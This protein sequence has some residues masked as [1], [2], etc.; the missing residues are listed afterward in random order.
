MDD[1]IE[2]L[3]LRAYNLGYE[4]E[5]KWGNCS[6]ATIRA[7]METYGEVD[8]EVFKGMAGFHGG[9]A[10]EIDGSCGAYASSIYFI[11][12]RYGRELDSLGEDPD[13]P[14]ASKVSQ[15][16][17]EVIKKIHDRFIEEYGSVIC[18]SIHR[19]V[20]GRPYYLVDSDD[21]RKFEEKGGHDWG[22]TSVVGKAAQWTVEVLESEEK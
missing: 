8:R 13:D 19:K 11:S 22:C 9:G 18:C 20:Y 16:M 12:L 21:M 1:R 7:I 6:Q 10:C 15:R 5:G 17:D 14:S 2:E 4:Y 3:K